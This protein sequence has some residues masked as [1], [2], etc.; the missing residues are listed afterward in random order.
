MSTRERIETPTKSNRERALAAL[1]ARKA[2]IDAM[3]ARLTTLSADH[4]EADPE[5][6]NWEHVGTLGRHAGLLRRIADMAFKEGE[7]AQ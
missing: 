5:E 3:L 1:I 4:F 6:I 7:H 2:E